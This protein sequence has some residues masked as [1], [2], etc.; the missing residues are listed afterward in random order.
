VETLRWAAGHNWASIVQHEEGPLW[1]PHPVATTGRWRRRQRRTAARRPRRCRSRLAPSS[2]ARPRPAFPSPSPTASP[3]RRHRGTLR[4]SFFSCRIQP[5]DA[6]ANKRLC[7]PCSLRVSY[8]R[9]RLCVSACSDKA[10]PDASAASPA[11]RYR[12][13]SPLPLPFVFSYCSIDSFGC[14]LSSFL[15][16][17]NELLVLVAIRDSE[18]MDLIWSQQ[19]VY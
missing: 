14:W 19:R 9:R 7:S 16:V 12:A 11:V 5:G 17:V 18:I 8:R 13:P 10:D 1:I 3:G 15:V 4:T 6:G 2:V